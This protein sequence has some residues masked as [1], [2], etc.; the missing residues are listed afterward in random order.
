M[1]LFSYVFLLVILLVPQTS[2]AQF[3]IKPPKSGTGVVVIELIQPEKMT[4]EEIKK[5][6]ANEPYSS[7][8]KKLQEKALKEW[9][10]INQPDY[11]LLIAYLD[12][13]TKSYEVV[14]KVWG[15]AYGRGA[16]LISSLPL[17]RDDISGR[18][19]YIGEVPAGDALVYGLNVQMAWQVRFD[20]GAAHF[21]V[22]DGGFIYIGAID[23]ALN[24][25]RVFSASEGG[26]LPESLK[27]YD[28][29]V[30]ICSQK[31]EGYSD[32]SHETSSRIAA[33]NYI[34]RM[35]DADINVQPAVIDIVPFKAKI[36][37]GW[38]NDATHECLKS[39][40]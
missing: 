5:G 22:P 11:G 6:L 26:V 17:Y 27:L 14:D 38:T 12:V 24:R 32:P 33:Q 7:N 19:W 13:P 20:N 35:L 23:G 9:K 15:A 16:G 21:V 1:K 37:N 39:T 34:R 25:Q 36:S 28:R 10:K 31:I 29:S 3:K 30:A 2:Y 18:Q 8:P 4:I 40:E